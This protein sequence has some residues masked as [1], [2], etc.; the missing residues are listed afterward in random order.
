M[1]YEGNLLVYDQVLYQ[2]KL[3]PSQEAQKC[4]LC[5]FNFHTFILPHR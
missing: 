1:L 5:V 3:T 2:V 4:L